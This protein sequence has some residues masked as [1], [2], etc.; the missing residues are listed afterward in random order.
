MKINGYEVT[1]ERLTQEPAK[2]QYRAMING[3]TVAVSRS[4]RAVLS[5]AEFLAK[6]MTP[7]MFAAL[8]NP[9]G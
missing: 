5:N 8:T 4:L 9:I 2:G 6:N 3:K 7:A 1:I